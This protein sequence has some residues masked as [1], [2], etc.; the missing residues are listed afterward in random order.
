MACRLHNLHDK[1]LGIDLRGGEVLMLPP[2][3]TS[4]AIVEEALYDNHHLPEW[5]RAGWIRRIA[6]RMDDVIAEAP[7]AR[8]A[9]SR[10][11]ESG[12]GR[13]KPKAKAAEA[14]AAGSASESEHP[15]KP[16]QE[17]TAKAEKKTE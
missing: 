2:H 13:A 1:T 4:R 17:I 6:A 11:L 10:H 3:S 14:K 15:D 16:P 5:E 12:E 9:E 7:G 8:A